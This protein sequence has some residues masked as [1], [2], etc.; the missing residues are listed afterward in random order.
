MKKLFRR[1][2]GLCCLL[3]LCSAYSAE[4]KNV[5][6][7]SIDDLRV[8]LGCYGA[9]HIIS[10]NFDKLAESGMLFENAFCQQAV[11]TPS[12]AVVFTGKRPDSVG[13]IHLRDHFR[14][15][16]P[17]ILTLPQLLQKHGYR[18]QSLGK[19]LGTGDSVS[20]TEPGM[21]NPNPR[22]LCTSARKYADP[23]MVNEVQ[24]E[25]DA[26]LE[27]GLTGIKF[28][29]AA[30]GP[31]MEIADVEDEGYYDGRLAIAAIAALRR[32]KDLGDPFFLGVGFTKPH[33]PFNAP[34]KYWDLYDGIDLPHL[35]NDFH[36]SK[37]PWFVL[38]RSA[39][40]HGYD[41]SPSGTVPMEIAM[42]YR[43]AYYACISYVDALLGKLLDEL[44]TLGLSESTSVI[45]WSDHGFK[46]GEHD[47]WGKS[48]NVE[49]D[50]RV[51]L[52]IRVPGEKGGVGRSSALVELVDLYA[53]VTDILEIDPPHQMEG[54]SL[55]PLL[56]NP[57][58][59]WKTAAFSQ[60][61]RSVG[62]DELERVAWDLMGY[63]IRTER[64]R[65]TR[66]DS[67]IV[68]G[69]VEGIELYDHLTD[70]EENYNVAREAKY[71]DVVEELSN[72]LDQ[73][74]QG[75]LPR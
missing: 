36:P 4:P 72:R 47:S 35:T 1:L 5:L 30:R 38:G 28:E 14:T 9:E 34:K 27:A 7:I 16:H 23:D 13:V 51:P 10:P 8:D 63:T 45:L 15:K 2:S 21:N 32:L 48:S 41:G 50:I 57:N 3:F 40:F 31:V 54:I 33:L 66:W 73:G 64:Y 18:T 65:L 75:A 25:Y 20:W 26:A 69:R 46:L 12:R 37:A 11:C 43:R 19:V 49:L 29:R 52:M 62:E 58:Q 24:A 56:K 71:A 17:D 22:N 70:S 67:V 55:L 42:N 44:D 68:P 6:F 59:P 61:P 39:E 53:T 60:Y 74:W